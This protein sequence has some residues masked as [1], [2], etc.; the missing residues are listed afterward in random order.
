MSNFTDQSIFQDDVT[1][2]V[3]A[4]F[5]EAMVMSLTVP[6]VK[7]YLDTGRL[8]VEFCADTKCDCEKFMQGCEAK[9]SDGCS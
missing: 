3:K 4:M 9:V 5:P 2:E 6:E 1:K 8:P 7:S